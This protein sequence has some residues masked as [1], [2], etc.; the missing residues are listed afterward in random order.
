MKLASSR[1]VKRPRRVAHRGGA[2]L[3]PENTLAAFRLGLQHG[4]DAVELDVHMSKDGALMV[5]HDPDV[6]RATGVVGEI[7][8]LT[9]AELRRLNAA[10]TYEGQD[11][12]PQPIPTL[13]DVLEL[14]R[15][16]VSVQLEI[17]LR[18]DKTRYAGI[19]AKVVEVLQQYDMLDH[20]VVIS[21]DFPT[22]Q[23]ITALEPRLQ[24]C[25]LVSSA[26][27]SRFGLRRNAAAVV[28]RLA[29]QG[30]RCVG[31]KHTWMTSRFLQALRAQDFRLGVWTVNDPVAIRK[32]AEMGVDFITSDRPDLLRQLIP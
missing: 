23:E 4:A 14:A 9:S 31:V 10:A 30:F 20:V 18:P 19:E 12:G 22:L 16:R 21:F 17:K 32:F 8:A 2:G 6:L 29:A 26:Y 11:F 28:D 7:G 1:H 27:L 3:A 25:A 15:G 5:M 24:T 13:Q